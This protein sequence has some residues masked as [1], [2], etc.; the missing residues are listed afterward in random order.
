MYVNIARRAVWTL[1][2]VIDS[3]CGRQVLLASFSDEGTEVQRSMTWSRAHNGG[4]LLLALG[5][6][7]QDQH[8]SPF[9]GICQTSQ[10][11]SI[12]EVFG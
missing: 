5:I 1:S 12:A 10:R 8:S 11:I 2:P 4:L 6:C 9:E 7:L 3:Q